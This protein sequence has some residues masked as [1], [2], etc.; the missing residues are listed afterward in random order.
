MN[1]GQAT[2]A[3]TPLAQA[4]PGRRAAPTLG[5]M[6]AALGVVY[7]DIGTSPLYALK[8]SLAILGT[9]SLADWEVLG[10]LSLIFWALVLIVTVKYVLLVMRADNR[11]EG[12]IL[13]L[14]ALAQRVS[15]GTRMRTALALVGITGACLFFGD[16]LIT[17]AISVLSALEGVEVTLPQ[18]K[19]V[20]LPISAMVIIALFAVQWY[21]TGRVGRVFGP[22]MALWFAALGALGA[23]QVVQHPGVL[24]ALAPY[25]AAQFCYYHGPLAFLALGAVVLAV[26]GAEAL[27]ADM[28][29]FGARPIRLSWLFFVLPALTLNYFGQGALVLAQPKA[30]ENPFYLMVPE[31]LR[32]PMVF[33]ATVAT[34]I[35][36][37]AVISGASTVA[38]QCMLLG[39][40]PRMTVRHTSQTASFNIYV[41]QL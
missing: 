38:R 7:G 4:P 12:G 35:A 8:S 11:G 13:A 14:M 31:P 16:G 26:T 41:P 33:L 32:L 25:Y 27:Y 34:V 3:L 9:R 24:V 21:G 6:L 19:E 37:Q 39:F 20:V 15:V 17:P 36:S 5:V 10:I 22:V 29:H 30:V 23:I 40:L 28:G 2:A 18:F 1:D